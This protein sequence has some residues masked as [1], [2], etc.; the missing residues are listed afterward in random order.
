M[1]HDIATPGQR[2]DIVTATMRDMQEYLHFAMPSNPTDMTSLSMH[3]E[4]IAYMTRAV[5]DF[6]E[7]SDMA[8]FESVI[9]QQDTFVREYYSG[10]LDLIYDCRDENYNLADQELA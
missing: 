10:V 2:Y 1:N 7:H 4:D 3:L 9:M 8:I 6:A 5:Q